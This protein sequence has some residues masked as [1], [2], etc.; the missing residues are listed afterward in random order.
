MKNKLK[1]KG[2][3]GGGRWLKWG[4]RPWVQSLVLPKK[5]N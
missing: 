1:A 4:M 2:L 5:K 3:G